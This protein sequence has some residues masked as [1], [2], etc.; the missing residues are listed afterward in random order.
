MML[1]QFLLSFGNTGL[2]NPYAIFLLSPKVAQDNFDLGSSFLHA[3]RFK[4]PHLQALL[5]RR[6]GKRFHADH[7]QY[8]TFSSV[9]DSNETKL[10]E[11]KVILS[12]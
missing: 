12:F 6:I 2:F 5:H 9:I 10:D 3:V 4:V 11:L 7:T 1:L 8:Q